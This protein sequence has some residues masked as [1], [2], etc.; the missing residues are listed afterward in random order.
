VRTRVLA[1]INIT[2]SDDGGCHEQVATDF[3]PKEVAALAAKHRTWW[4][5]SSGA[6]PASGLVVGRPRIEAGTLAGL[7]VMVDSATFSRS[8]L[9]EAGHRAPAPRDISTHMIAARFPNLDSKGKLL[10]YLKQARLRGVKFDVGHGAQSLVLRNA[11]PAV[12]QG[13]WPDTISTDLHVVSM[14]APMMD[15]PRTLSKLWRWEFR[16]K[17]RSCARP[18][19]AQVIHRPELGHLTVGAG[20]RCGRVERAARRVRIRR[21]YG[22][23]VTAR[24]AALICEMTLRD[25]QIVWDWNARAA[26]DYHKLGPSMAFGRGSIA[27]FTEEQSGLLSFGSMWSGEYNFVLQTWCSGLPHPLP[28][29]VSGVL[30]SLLNP[31]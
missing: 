7:P 17:R 1:L 4:S 13:F 29:H 9:L 19:S 6:L 22:G 28:E 24:G 26:A 25:G 31:S 14:N 20:R 3:Q 5:A 12:A 18:G 11:A 2:D 27:S 15:M 10:D 23:R 8:A 16:S 21:A 30:W